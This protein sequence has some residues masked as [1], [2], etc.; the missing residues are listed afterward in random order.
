VD[1]VLKIERD[2]RTTYEATI[3]SPRR[4]RFEGEITLVEDQIVRL[5]KAVQD[6][7]YD[8]LDM[9][10]AAE[11]GAASRRENGERIFYVRAGD[12]DKRIDANYVTVPELDRLQESILAELPSKLLTDSDAGIP[13]DTPGAFVADKVNKVFH[14]PGCDMVGR[15]GASDRE[16]YETPFDALNFG[17]HPCEICRPLDT[18]K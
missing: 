8:Q 18:P 13:E 17:Y 15:I 1:Y 12:L 3:R 7:R 10:Y 5:Y 11:D 6:A 4:R 2:G 14:R 9:Q 16:S